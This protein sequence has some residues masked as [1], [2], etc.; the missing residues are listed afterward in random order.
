MISVHI[1]DDSFGSFITEFYV[2]RSHSDGTKFVM[3][4]TEEQPLSWEPVD[5]T[6]GAIVAPSF[7]VPTE[8]ARALMDALVHHYHGAD[9][10]RAL[11]KDYDAERAR[12][13]M[14]TEALVKLQSSSTQL[15]SQAISHGGR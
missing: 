10:S 3:R 14:L 12:V 11:R 5:T 15:L 4:S 13:D 7:Q 8:A 9:D 2:I 1:K 6:S